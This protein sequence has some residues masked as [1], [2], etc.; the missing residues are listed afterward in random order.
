MY[1]Q[2]IY[3]YWLERD[4][5]IVMTFNRILLCDISLNNDVFTRK[6][7]PDMTSR[8]CYMGEE[9]EVIDRA[10]QSIKSRSLVHIYKSKS[11]K[12][13]KDLLYIRCSIFLTV[14]VA[15]HCWIVDVDR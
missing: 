10:I 11:K 2:Y 5:R 1:I 7:W 14:S 3:I 13:E 12:K 4:Q 15:I 6:I 9:H 8:H